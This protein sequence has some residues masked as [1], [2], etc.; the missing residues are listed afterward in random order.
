MEPTA[1]N[2]TPR[3]SATI[4]VVRD[5]TDGLEVLLARRNSGSRVLAN[6]YVFPGGKLEQSDQSAQILAQLDQSVRTLYVHLGE[7]ASTPEHAAAL[8]VAAIREAAEESDLLFLHAEATVAEP[9][10]RALCARLRDGEPL[11]ALLAETGAALACSALAPWSRWIT[12][13]DAPVI[14][15]RFDTRFFLAKAPAGQGARA[16]AFEINELCWLT[17][18]V[19]LER[20]AAREILLIPPQILSLM[21]LLNYASADEAL[22]A[23]RTH[24]PPL[25]EPRIFQQQGHTMMCYPGDAEHPVQQSA[26]PEWVPTRLRLDGKHFAPLQGYA[27]L[28]HA[29][30]PGALHVA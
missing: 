24:Q 7:P 11:T 16:D 30:R 1:K 10:S 14:N 13:R 15:R 4:V 19:A 26:F 6:A 27:P 18:K 25:I 28:L 8:Y 17:P 9:E 5:G 22:R 21:H 20:Y 29:T 12:P 3:D 23:A 2:Q